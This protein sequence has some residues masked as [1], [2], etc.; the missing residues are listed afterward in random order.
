NK[1]ASFA[2]LDRLEGEFLHAEGEWTGGNGHERRVAVSFGP[3]HGPVTAKQVEYALHAAARR[4]YDD[5]VFAGFS[6]D[7][8]AQAVIQE[9]PNPRVRVHL[10]HIRPDV[11]M[12]GLLKETPNSQLFTVFGTPR[13]KLERVKDSEYRVVMEGV[14][15]YNPVDNTIHATKADKVAAW[16]LDTDYDGRTFCITQ[17]F[18][19]DRSAWDKLAR[20]LK[21]TVAEDVW[22][23]FTGTTSLPFPAGEHKRVAVKVID[24]R[25]NEVVRVLRVEA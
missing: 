14:D 19:P 22:T 6:F 5:L 13:A 17:A 12:T 4:G 21:S 15:I 20:A 10:A 1:V 24:P 7:A 18:F 23:E 11:Q 25:G 8:A 9:D 16:F 2:R 3:E